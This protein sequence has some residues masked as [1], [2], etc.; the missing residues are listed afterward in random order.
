MQIDILED[1]NVCII[2]LGYVGL[3]LAVAMADVGYRV[4]GVEINDHVRDCIANGKAHFSETGID[5]RIGD[6]V[7]RGVLTTSKQLT[8]EPQSSVYIITVGTPVDDDKKTKMESIKHVAQD[9]ANVLKDGDMVILRSTVRVGVCA[10]VV[11]PILDT[12]NVRYDLAFC[13]E[14]TIEGKAIEELRSLPQVVGGMNQAS[15]LRASRLFHM[16]TPS[17]VRVSSLEAAEMVKLVSNTF[18]D[19][20]FAFANE[21]ALAADAAGLSA[22]EVIT[23]SN[24]GYPRGGVKSPGPVGGPCLEKDP[25]ILA[26]GLKQHGFTPELSLAGRRLNE[27]L[28]QQVATKLRS[29]AADRD[30]S[31]RK[32]CV[33]GLAFKGRPATSDLRGTLAKPLIGKMQDAFPAAQVTGWDPVAK[34]EECRDELGLN[35]PES[36]A[37]A[38]RD[39]DLVIIQT[40]H[41][42]FEDMD[43]ADISTGMSSNGV[44]FDLWSMNEDKNLPLTNGVVYACYGSA[45]I[46]A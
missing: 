41:R 45:H 3:T 5:K 30:M 11:K 10:D 29:V 38:V 40:N 14:R 12:A 36:L 16:L 28:P 19:I 9:V 6:L 18:R 34:P 27:A 17:V 25:Y 31:I 46:I 21:I 2:G 4:H 44:I 39:A 42:D 8:T 7:S 15:T 22:N 1:T 20:M 26:E 13:P 37:E 33:L 35:M 24:L 23:A 32:I 43:F